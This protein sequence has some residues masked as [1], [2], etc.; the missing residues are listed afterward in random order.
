MGL[1]KKRPTSHKLISL[2]SWDGAGRRGDAAEAAVTVALWWTLKLL[3][4]T[5]QLLVAVL[6]VCGQHIQSDDVLSS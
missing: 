5:A 1:H 4:S 3:Q 2:I 6:F